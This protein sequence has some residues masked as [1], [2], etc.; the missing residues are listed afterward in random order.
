MTGLVQ[1]AVIVFCCFI[2]LCA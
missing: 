1:N 2:L